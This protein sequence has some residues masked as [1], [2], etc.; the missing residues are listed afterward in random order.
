M[1]IEI[2][3]ID[4]SLLRILQ[5]SDV[6]PLVIRLALG[7]RLTAQ[8]TSQL[9]DGRVLLDVKG[10]AVEARSALPLTSGQALQLEVAGLGQ[11]IALRVLGDGQRVSE[12]NFALGALAVAH[13]STPPSPPP[14]VGALLRALD[15]EV[16]T[17]PSA[18]RS[19]IGRLLGPL[20]ADAATGSIAT[21]IQHILE[22]G[23]LLF[24]SRLRSWLQ[25]GASTAPVIGSATGPAAGLPPELGSD[26][27]V[28]L[29]VLGRAIQAPAAPESADAGARIATATEARGADTLS[30]GTGSATSSAPATPLLA[31]AAATGPADLVAPPGPNAVAVDLRATQAPGTMTQASTPVTPNA[32][33]PQAPDAASTATLILQQALEAEVARLPAAQR[34]DLARVLGVPPEAREAAP[35]ANALRQV[36]APGPEVASPAV[37]QAIA[38]LQHLQPRAGAVVPG[39]NQATAEVPPELRTLLGVLGRAL[40]ATGDQPASPPPSAAPT[41]AAP[42]AEDTRAAP[43]SHQPA[44]E[45][46][47]AQTPRDLPPPHLDALQRRA[48]ELVHRE[49]DAIRL[50]DRSTLDTLRTEHGRVRDELLSRQVETAYHW[51]RDGTLSLQL[52]LDFGGQLVHAWLRFH[53]G[54]DEEPAATAAPPAVF[55]FDLAL[56]PPGIGPMRAHVAWSARYLRV[57]FFVAAETAAATI[58]PALPDLSSALVRTGFAK[59]D[60]NVAVDPTRCRMSAPDEMTPPEGGSILN[61]R[62]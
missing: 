3:R 11:E 8:V 50:G 9:A 31:T 51:V 41:Q 6:E 39:L 53:R 7:E 42:R 55:S 61:L 24:E 18:Q 15:V 59:V 37:Q 1:P 22:N 47:Q 30:P 5:G 26:L 57:Q 14:D 36:L 33:A 19:E 48:V 25:G 28:L 32:A 27:K 49:L 20:R 13:A 35:L 46:I 54:E 17:L 43:A 16:T 60:A 62:A 52:P 2:P 23:G 38:A 45:G 12:R 34:T 44:A 21:E 58:S 4:S 10:H 40:L 29:G 56:S